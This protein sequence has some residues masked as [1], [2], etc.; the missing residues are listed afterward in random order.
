MLFYD[1]MAHVAAN[2]DLEDWKKSFGGENDEEDEIYDDI[3]NNDKDD[4]IMDDGN[5]TN[6]NNNE[7]TENKNK[8]P[9]LSNDNTSSNKKLAL[10]KT[11]S[12]NSSGNRKKS[13]V[14]SM[15][16]TSSS[17]SKKN[18]KSWFLTHGNSFGSPKWCFMVITIY[19]GGGF[20]GMVFLSELFCNETSETICFEREFYNFG[21]FF[22][23]T[24]YDFYSCVF[25]I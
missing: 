14:K 13:R 15:S 1:T 4:K 2:S 11:E 7:K 16:V 25:I 8:K 3:D 10:K 17:G 21:M 12:N 9:K 18:K 19:F 6:T 5:E 20:V 22:F 24:N 23:T